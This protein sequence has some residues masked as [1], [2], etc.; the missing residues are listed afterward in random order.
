MQRKYVCMY[1][2]MYVQYVC[3]VCMYEYKLHIIGLTL[4]WESGNISFTATS[5]SLKAMTIDLKNKN[6]YS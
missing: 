4:T 3:T 2:C 5:K 6:I 1:A